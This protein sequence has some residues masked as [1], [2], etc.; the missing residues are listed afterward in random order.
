MSHPLTTEELHQA[1][2]CATDAAIEAGAMLRVEFHRADGPRGYKDHAEIDLP[3]EETIRERLL[4]AY[5]EWGFLGEETESELFPPGKPYWVV[6]PNDGTVEFLKGA[7]GS[8]V[9]IGLVHQGKAVLGVVYAPVAPD[10]DGDLFTWHEGV[11]VLR[12]G[13]AL[14]PLS[15]N[16]PRNEQILLASLGADKKPT[17]NLQLIQPGRFRSS[18]SIAYRLALTAAGEADIGISIQNPKAW[19]VAGGHAILRGVGG[20]I[21]SD[22]H[23]EL[24]YG[25]TGELIGRDRWLLGGLPS[26][27]REYANLHWE[28]IFRAQFDVTGKETPQYPA[29]WSPGVHY[30]GDA[31]I[32][33]RAQGCL[34]GQLAGDALGSLVEFHTPEQI[35]GKYPEGGPDRIESGGVWNTL[36]GQPTDDSELALLLARSIIARGEYNDQAAL[37]S[38]RWWYRS[39]PFDIGT[40]VGKALAA[41]DAVAVDTL[42]AA[43][44]AARNNVASEAN[45]ALMRVSPLGI[46]F[47]HEKNPRP[48]AEAAIADALL[49]HASDVCQ[50][51][52]AV[53]V[54]AVATAIR[55]GHRYK[56]YQAALTWSEQFAPAA[57]TEALLIAQREPPSDFI[58][59]QGWVVLALHN[60]FYQLL[61]APNFAVGV[62]DTVRSGGDTD[63]NAAIAGSLLGALHGRD[64]VPLQWRRAILSCH[65]QN[66]L[67]HIHHPRPPALWGV[68]ALILAEKLLLL[69]S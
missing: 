63:T 67:T 11:S 2:R 17:I 33:A 60:A 38:Y 53:Y 20:T 40:T 45:G 1:L 57:I 14:P 6:D 42:S 25:P 27:I 19:D 48:I 21:R 41:A 30:R 62:I 69:R 65:S 22:S 7:R 3:M 10:D 29:R 54:I 39:K 31:I 4:T 15:S 50:A 26:I 36:A 9:S 52:N 58:T 37:V 34:L 32:L 51:A 55:T 66:G 8:S 24:V 23:E 47:A 18:P 43:H 68:D 46:Y 13:I 59:K 35:A 5:P 16:I 56:T 61:H 44:E 12:N 28:E 49:T 64:A